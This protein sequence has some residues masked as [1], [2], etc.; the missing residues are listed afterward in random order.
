MGSAFKAKERLRD[1]LTK[2]QNIGI[3]IKRQLADE[4]RELNR[5]VKPGPQGDLAK[6]LRTWA[7]SQG[8]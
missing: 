5:W 3:N 8:S 1:K 7:S 4:K 2:T 6:L